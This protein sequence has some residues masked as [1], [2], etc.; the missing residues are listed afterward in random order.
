MRNF[1]PNSTNN[2]FNTLLAGMLKCFAYSN[3]L[4]FLFFPNNPFK[5]V[6]AI[7]EIH[8][9]NLIPGILEHSRENLLD[10]IKVSSMYRREGKYIPWL[11]IHFRLNTNDLK[12]S[13]TSK[14]QFLCEIFVHTSIHP[15]TQALL[16]LLISSV[17]PHVALSL[18]QGCSTYSDMLAHN[19][20]S[21][22][23]RFPMQ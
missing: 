9:E 1:I 4:P 15:R 17:L 23:S 13:I 19:F 3:N 21:P 14:L 12:I 18:I 22:A 2:I 20:G 16:A 7:F 6:N 10:H 11:G 5:D 8:Q